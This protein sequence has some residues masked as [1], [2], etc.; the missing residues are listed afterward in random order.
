MAGMGC[1]RK[2]GNLMDRLKRLL[3]TG[4]A[5]CCLGSGLAS[6]AVPGSAAQPAGA[7]S[8]VSAEKARA[9]A[10]AKN[11][12]SKA[13]RDS[14]AEADAKILEK[15]CLVKGGTY[16][17]VTTC[18]QGLDKGATGLDPASR[19]YYFRVDRELTDKFFRRVRAYDEKD[20]TQIG[21]YYVAKDLSSVWRLDGAQPGM[22][23]GSADK[24]MKKTRLQ[25]Y[26]RYLQLGEKGIVRLRTP[27]EVPYTLKVKSLDENV[28]SVDSSNQLIPQKLGRTDILVEAQVGDVKDSGTARVFVVTKEELQQMAYRSYLS[29]LYL[30]EMMMLDDFYWRS[31]WGAPFYGPAYLGHRPPPPHHGGHRPPPPPRGHR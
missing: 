7:A 25:V 14:L 29:R 26:P 5:V 18:L 2:E 24:V 21:E 31:W 19:P 22:I 23:A 16:K 15:F 30:N 9:P 12:G 8:A 17:K 10:A 28:V 6:A 3:C 27:G 11:D 13:I 20:K 4:L 1:C